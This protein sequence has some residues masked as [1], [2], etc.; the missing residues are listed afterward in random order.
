MLYTKFDA[1][2]TSESQAV[3]APGR[4]EIRFSLFF[5]RRDTSNIFVKVTCTNDYSRS[6]KERLHFVLKKTI[7]PSNAS[8]TAIKWHRE[9]THGAIASLFP[10]QAEC[11]TLWPRTTSMHLHAAVEV[12][13]SEI[14]VDEHARPVRMQVAAHVI[15][16]ILHVG[17]HLVEA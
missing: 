10:T 7:C 1:N 15:V 14:S 3:A 8:C 9:K 4:R 5:S 13:A 11:D 2:G 17:A 16:L 12:V 6:A